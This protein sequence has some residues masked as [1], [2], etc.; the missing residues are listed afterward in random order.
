MIN[1]S[2]KMSNLPKAV[3]TVCC[4]VLYAVLWYMY[5]YVTKGM[6]KSYYTTAYCS[7]VGVWSMTTLSHLL[8]TLHVAAVLCEWVKCRGTL[9]PGVKH[10]NQWLCVRWHSYLNSKAGLLQ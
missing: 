1:C 7:A 8:S 9:Y 6:D 10:L 2:G 3:D 4:V 5:V